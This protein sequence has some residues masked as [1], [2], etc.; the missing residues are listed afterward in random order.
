M[1]IPPL[2]QVLPRI[3]VGKTAA[4]FLRLAGMRQSDGIAEST[5]SIADFLLKRLILSSASCE[6]RGDGGRAWSSLLC[7]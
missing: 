7:R 4:S 5:R 2:P 1:I 6:D 3:R